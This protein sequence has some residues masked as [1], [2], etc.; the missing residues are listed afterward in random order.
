MQESATLAA[1]TPSGSL[2][3][4]ALNWHN[5][6]TKRD[7][8]KWK[9]V[10]KSESGM[11][12][13]SSMG[14]VSSDL[15]ESPDWQKFDESWSVDVVHWN[16]DAVPVRLS[17]SWQVGQNDVSMGWVLNQLRKNIGSCI[18][19]NTCFVLVATETSA[20]LKLDHKGCY[21]SA[22]KFLH[23][24][25]NAVPGSNVHFKVTLNYILEQAQDSFED[26]SMD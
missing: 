5:E 21:F 26:V 15:Q 24:C 17:F 10:A 14:K 8:A 13:T 22:R 20:S 4:E 1:C 2:T 6:V 7:N 25:I 18:P 12:I 23:T 11:S 3:I 9:S 16:S 19:E